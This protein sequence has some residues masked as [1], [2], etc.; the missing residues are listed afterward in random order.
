MSIVGPIAK[1]I[2]GLGFLVVMPVAL[3]T[4][5]VA[6]FGDF[7]YERQARRVAARAQV[8]AYDAALQTYER[9]TGEFPTTTQGLEAL[10]ANPG[11]AGWNGP[12]V[13][14]EISRDPWGSPFV[15]R[16][17]GQEIPEI[18]SLGADRKPGPSNIS[19]LAPSTPREQSAF[20]EALVR[21]TLLVL[22][23]LALLLYPLLPRILAKRKK[24]V[25]DS[26][27]AG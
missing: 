3:L 22:S 11:V 26:N 4:M 18:L 8:Q 5:L 1:F 10:H 9:D 19:N 2:Y 17:R 12:Y 23:S 20:P 14:K 15:Y 16:N 7:G 24:P 13:D 21:T 6:L 25:L 27:R